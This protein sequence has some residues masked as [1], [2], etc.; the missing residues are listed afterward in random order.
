MYPLIG[1]RQKEHGVR[2]FIT[3]RYAYLIY[4][5]INEAEEEIIILSVKHFAQQRE[6]E[7]T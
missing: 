3:P 7:D 4:Y 5:A 1:K 2:K 6:F